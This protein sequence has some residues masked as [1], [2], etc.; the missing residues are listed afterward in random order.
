MPTDD[1]EDGGRPLSKT[2]ARLVEL[3][4]KATQGEI[5]KIAAAST[6]S[7]SNWEA[8]IH[9]PPCDAIVRLAAHWKVSVEYLLGLSD[10]RSGLAPDSWLVDLDALE[11]GRPSEKWAAKVPRR[12]RIVDYE[13]LTKL[14][15]AA[16]R[17]RKKGGTDGVS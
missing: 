11:A 8:G 14:K 13:E 6:S 1:R 16:D 3:R 4:G 9:S 15:A 17:K 5:A 12:F 2:A 10:F 7:I